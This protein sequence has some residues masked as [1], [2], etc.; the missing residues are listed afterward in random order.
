M[1]RQRTDNGATRERQ[2]SDNRYTMERQ[3]MERHLQ[4]S[5][6]VGPIPTHGGHIA[7]VLG[8][9]GSLFNTW[10]MY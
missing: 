2:W 6:V 10:S 1:E 4:C 3:S 7:Q 5:T 8:K 9:T